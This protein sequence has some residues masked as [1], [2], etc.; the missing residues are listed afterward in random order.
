VE[1]V[2]GLSYTLD[3]FLGGRGKPRRPSQAQQIEFNHPTD[4]P[5]TYDDREFAELN[6]ISYSL[7]QLLGEDEK[8]K[9]QSQKFHDASLPPEQ[10]KDTK[11]MM[12]Q[13]VQKVGMEVGLRGHGNGEIL[14]EGNKLYFIVI[15]LAPGDYHRFHS[16]TNWVAES[17]R[18]FAGIFLLLI[19]LT[20]Q[21]NY[22]RYLRT[23]QNAYRICL[24]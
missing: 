3:T 16:P 15:Y 7:D 5:P 2:K 24:R 10:S 4:S 13:D 20:K 23:L 8:Q 18:H 9:A 19:L 11:E 21:A 12:V 6:G 14:R 17:R 1:Q 22:S